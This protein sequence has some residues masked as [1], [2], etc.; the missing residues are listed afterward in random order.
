MYVHH[1]TDAFMSQV[2]WEHC[3]FCLLCFL[4]ICKLLK[5]VCVATL[6][7]GSRK[8]IHLWSTCYKCT[9]KKE[10]KRKENTVLSTGR[11]NGWFVWMGIISSKKCDMG[12][13]LGFFFFLENIFLCKNNFYVKYFREC[14]IPDKITKIVFLISP[15]NKERMLSFMVSCRKEILKKCP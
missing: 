8:D 3:I 7:V 15:E 2:S 11:Y 14:F 12:I 1:N 10:K 13:V 4:M 5:L 6:L 9:R